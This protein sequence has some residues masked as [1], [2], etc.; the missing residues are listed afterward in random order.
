[1]ALKT[2]EKMFLNMRPLKPNKGKYDVPQAPT[3]SMQI[4][5]G[6]EGTQCAQVHTRRA[7]RSL[8]QVVDENWG[9]GLGFGVWGLRFGV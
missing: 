5:A 6:L 9:S 8:A 2:S 1:M 4:W 7:C 3:S